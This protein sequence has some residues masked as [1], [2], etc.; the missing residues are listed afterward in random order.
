MVGCVCE[1]QRRWGQSRD[2]GVMRIA[3]AWEA[4]HAA[5]IH[6]N[7]ARTARAGKWFGHGE[8]EYSGPR[9][10]AGRRSGIALVG[11]VGAAEVVQRW[12]VAMTHA[13]VERASDAVQRVFELFADVRLVTVRQ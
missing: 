8:G 2:D 7:V 11:E 10:A 12:L 6:I 9:E 13:L 1:E 3:P 4:R 5:S